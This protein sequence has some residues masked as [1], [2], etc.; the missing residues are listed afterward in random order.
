MNT[1]ACNPIIETYFAQL[2]SRISDLPRPQREELVKELRAHVM[3]R[4]EQMAVAGAEDCR[5]VL[6]AL[7][8]PDEIARQFRMELILR[9]SS[10]RISPIAILR[11]CAR[12]TVAGIQGYA[13]FIVAV[14]G[15]ALALS[16]YLT[17]LLKPF[18]PRNV[19]LFIGEQGLNLTSFPVPPH[20]HE[21]LG[22]YYIPVAVVIGYLFTLGTTLLIRFLLRRGRS[23]R[24][25][26]A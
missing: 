19:G 22:S 16:F 26:L 2:N 3:D 24:Q 5:T 14:V 11:T 20:G 10:W 8:T 7:G 25:R 21:C 18:F 17:A 13:I 9:R 15:Y 4:L 1:V 23:L 6:K 12:W